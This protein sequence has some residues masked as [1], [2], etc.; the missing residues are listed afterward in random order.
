L[1]LDARVCDL[2]V[3]DPYEQ[4]D[5]N[6]PDLNSYLADGLKIERTVGFGTVL[7]IPPWGSAGRP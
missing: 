5:P 3:V 2:T 4:S 1:P 7:A 6:E